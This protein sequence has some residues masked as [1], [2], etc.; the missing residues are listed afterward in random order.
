MRILLRLAVLALGV[1]A[2]FEMRA[3]AQVLPSK[4]IIIPVDGV[5][6]AAIHPTA[7]KTRVPRGARMSR[8]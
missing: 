8:A 4:P 7:A 6:F 2:V 1:A 5:A 3:V